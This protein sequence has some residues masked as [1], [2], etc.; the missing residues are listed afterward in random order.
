MIKSDIE[1]SKS[2][3]A[4]TV[5]IINVGKHL[6]NVSAMLNFFAFIFPDPTEA[7]AQRSTYAQT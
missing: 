1:L 4:K 6:T 3:L 5:S 7:I 2:E